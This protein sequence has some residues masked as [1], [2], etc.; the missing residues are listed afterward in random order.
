MRSHRVGL[1]VTSVVAAALV[2]E[3][4]LRAL[5]TSILHPSLPGYLWMRRDAVFGMVNVPGR[6]V[7]PPF[8]GGRLVGTV[9]I[10]ARGL[11]VDG[12]GARP[13]GGSRVVCLG[14]SSTFGIQLVEGTAGDARSRYGADNGYPARLAARLDAEV[15][16]AGVIGYNSGH[17]LRQLRGTVLPL[18]RPGVVVVRFGFNDHAFFDPTTLVREP[19]WPLDALMYLAAGL[20]TTRLLAGIRPQPVGPPAVSIER[21]VQNLRAMVAFARAAGARV[22]FVD[23][24]LRPRAPGEQQDPAMAFM[25]LPPLDVLYANHD[26]YQSALAR[27]AADLDVPLVITAG[28]VTFGP[29]DRVHPDPAGADAIAERIAAHLRR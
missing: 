1:V 5:P 23:Y 22:L 15:V 18:L 12:G 16:N 27:V 21:F 3:L 28:A 19:G 24:P 11:R 20:E 7:D 14:D 29:A 4:A 13:P 26:R 10:D 17:G 6:F 9:E 25:G 8:G 2:G